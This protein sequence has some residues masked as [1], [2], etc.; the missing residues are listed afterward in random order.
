MFKK[1]FIILVS[2][3]I[4]SQYIGISHGASTGNGGKQSY[5]DLYSDAKKFVLRAKKFLLYW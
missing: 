5:S 4:F 2:V 1:I 3:F